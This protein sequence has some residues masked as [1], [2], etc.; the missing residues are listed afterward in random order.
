MKKL[1]LTLAMGL[2]MAL[3]AGCGKDKR[4][5]EESLIKPI[6]VRPITVKEITIEETILKE[7]ILYEDIVQYW[8]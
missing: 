6:E 4:V 2:F 1:L 7:E 8:D 5:K 3:A